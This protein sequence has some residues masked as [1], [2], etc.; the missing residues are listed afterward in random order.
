MEGPLVGLLLAAGSSRR[1]GADKLTQPLPEGDWLAVRA[2][3]NLLA[4]IDRVLAVVP[5]PAAG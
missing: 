3:R 5:K 2:C 1:F 4:G